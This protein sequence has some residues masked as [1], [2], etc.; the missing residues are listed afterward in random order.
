V[1]GGNSHAKIDS[2]S[3]KGCCLESQMSNVIHHS[4]VCFCQVRRRF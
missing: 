1:E 2:K 4:S 3:I